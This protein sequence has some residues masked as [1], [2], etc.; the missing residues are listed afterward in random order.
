MNSIG[1]GR[2]KGQTAVSSTARASGNAKAASLSPAAA[3]KAGFPAAHHSEH[4]AALG[5]NGW[6]ATVIC[7]MSR[8]CKW[9]LANYVDSG[10]SMGVF[11]S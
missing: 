10:V 7:G 3:V 6:L 4:G 2:R 11:C 5:A 9:R 1:N 8:D